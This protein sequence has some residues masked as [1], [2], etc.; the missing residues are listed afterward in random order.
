MRYFRMYVLVN[1]MVVGVVRSAETPQDI[2]R[3]VATSPVDE[4]PPQNKELLGGAEGP[5]PDEQAQQVETVDQGAPRDQEINQEVTITNVSPRLATEVL[6]SDNVAQPSEIVP[7]DTVRVSNDVDLQQPENIQGPMLE[8]AEALIELPLQEV[9]KNEISSDIPMQPG[10]TPSA[11]PQEPV[12]ATVQEP[13][14]ENEVPSRGIDTISLEQPQGNW[15][16]KR[17]WWERAEELYK[18]IRINVEKID[19]LRVKFFARR[20][21][22]DK[23]ILDRFYLDIGLT[24]GELQASMQLL[25]T[26]L[27]QERKKE[28]MLSEE[29]RE[30]MA[31][32]QK[33]RDR[34][35][36]LQRD[37]AAV[38]SLRD[39]ADRVIDRVIDQKKRVS[40]YESEAWEYMREIGRIVSDT[41]ASE[42]YYR[43][44]A[45]W[46]TVKDIHRY[47]EQDLSRFLDMLLV[48]AKEQ[49]ERIKTALQGLKEQGIDLKVR[50][51]EAQEQ[52]VEQE[53]A[54]E[55]KD[56]KPVVTQKTG[57][58]ASTSRIFQ[59]VID[60]AIW[61]FLQS[62]WDIIMWL[63]RRIYSSITALFR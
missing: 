21:E 20:T 62:I 60:V 18:K 33:D 3:D 9:P 61:Q 16:F 46:R 19:D 41:Q 34:L 12:A 56:K 45:G 17:Y 32:A 5:L 58:L 27:E 30:I 8:D 63:P 57:W 6:D 42:L 24:Q 15:L 54:V 23:T 26:Q 14:V 22:L 29:E 1:V 43:M 53:E 28:G 37:V 25:M 47:I 51:Q 35:E 40:V 10:L 38:V 11:I 44:D 59:A 7:V 4:E 31:A 49:T 39:T 55:E 52:I 36:Q 2:L 13:E 50:M 48:N